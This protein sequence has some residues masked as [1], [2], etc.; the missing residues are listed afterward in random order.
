VAVAA[1]ARVAPKR[2]CPSRQ[3]TGSITI[4]LVR[5]WRLERRRPYILELQSRVFVVVDWMGKMVNTRFL[6]FDNGSRNELEPT[7]GMTMGDDGDTEM[8]KLFC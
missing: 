4:T 7:K 2:N 1:D 5:R 8:I 6:V 3:A